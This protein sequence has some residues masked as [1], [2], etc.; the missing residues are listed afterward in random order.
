MPLSEARLSSAKCSLF[1][2]RG[3]H[4]KRFSHHTESIFTRIALFTA[5]VHAA[6]LLR[7]FALACARCKTI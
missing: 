3:N 1:T 7:L 5:R 2:T 6:L 4:P